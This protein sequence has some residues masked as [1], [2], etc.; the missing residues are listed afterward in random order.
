MRIRI[1]GINFDSEKTINKKWIY[2]FSKQYT[3][4]KKLKTTGMY[5]ILVFFSLKKEKN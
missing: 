1:Q 3:N 4:M 2:F 5:K